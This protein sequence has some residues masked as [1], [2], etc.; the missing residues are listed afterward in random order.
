M[1]LSNQYSDCEVLDLDPSEAK[2]GPFVAMQRAIDPN[3]PRQQENL[4]FLRRDGT[5]VECATHMSTPEK[6]RVSIVFDALPDIIKLLA[7]L[8][9]QAK[10]VRVQA[11]DPARLTA[12]L[13][14]VEAEGG[15]LAHIRCQ[16][17]RH[18]QRQAG[19]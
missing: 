18:R 5:W 19:Y 3:D 13:Q 7:E 6:E 12:M 17:A 2:R 4:Y 15:L 9:P 14:Q 1:G 11:L 16:V 8:P 10:S